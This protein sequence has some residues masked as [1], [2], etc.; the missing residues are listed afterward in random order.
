MS[1]V[2]KSGKGNVGHIVLY[3]SLGLLAVGGIVV[4]I[5][6]LGK[7]KGNGDCKPKCNGKHCGDDGC[8]GKC[9]PGCKDG[10][11]CSAGK[12]VN[13]KCSGDTD[14]ANFGQGYTCKAGKCVCTSPCGPGDCGKRCGE[15]CGK[16]KTCMHG[17]CVKN[18]CQ[19]ETDW[20]GPYCD[21]KDTKCG[22]CAQ[23]CSSR[24]ICTDGACTCNTGY[25]NLGEDKC[26]SSCA[27][28][29]GGNN[30]N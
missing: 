11:L 30:K 2:K 22:P 9:P 12:C 4:L 13:N 29:Y 3:S 8:S 18:K 21:Q 7:G 25:V 24:G 17:T 10:E 20:K 27:A 16:G 19:C 26:C 14:C 28:G 5:I 15:N 23:G 1:T 6:F